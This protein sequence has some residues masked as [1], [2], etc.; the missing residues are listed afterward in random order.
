MPPEAGHSV[1]PSAE[2]IETV[3]AR[4][5]AVELEKERENELRARRARP[6][7]LLDGRQECV[8]VCQ[9][10]FHMSESC[11]RFAVHLRDEL[12]VRRNVARLGSG[13]PSV[14]FTFEYPIK[15]F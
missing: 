14:R 11:E 12:L 1:N 15:F 10:Y 7:S 5:A 6:V 8:Y 3:F 4:A 9:K 13:R 2:A